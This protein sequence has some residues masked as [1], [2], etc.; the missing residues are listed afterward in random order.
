MSQNPIISIKNLS[1]QYPSRDLIL[2][3]VSL[4]VLPGDYLG[5]VGPNGSG[6]TTLL[7]LI[8]GL[9]PLKRGSIELFGK[10]IESFS[11]WDKIGYIPQDV[12]QGDKTFPATVREVIESGLHGEQHHFGN[13][14]KKECLPMEK[15]IDMVNVRGLLDRRIGELSGGEERRVFIARALIS[16]PE[17]LILDEPTSGVDFAGEEAFFSLLKQLNTEHGITIFLVSHDLEALAHNAKTALC[18]N[19]KVVYFGPAE[20]LHSQAVIESAFGLRA[21]HATEI[22]EHGR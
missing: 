20:G 11:D 4:E 19:R 12:F 10:P 2:E 9:L 17:L 22:Y 6:K 21:W 1:Y 8:L 13:F 3:G 5:A 7:K 15:A 18:L 16:E 14:R